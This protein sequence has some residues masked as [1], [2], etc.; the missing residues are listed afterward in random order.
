MQSYYD[1]QS[2]LLN[3]MQ[4]LECSAGWPLLTDLPLLNS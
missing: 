2:V 4:Q 1:T 3:Q